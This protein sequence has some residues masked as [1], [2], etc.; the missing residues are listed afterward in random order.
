MSTFSINL[1]KELIEN[2]ILSEE[3]ALCE[4]AGIVKSCGEISLRQK[5]EKIVLVTEFSELYKR[6]DKL[7][8][9]LYNIGCE[10]EKSDEQAYSR[11]RYE[12][13]INYPYAKTLLVDT[14]I[15]SV[16]ENGFTVINKGISP[17]LINSENCA[18]AFLRGV[19]LGGF[20]SNILLSKNIKQQG[21]GYQVEFNLSS[22]EFARDFCSLLAGFDI[23][24]KMITR[25][26][27]YNVYIKEFNQICM[28]LCE[29]GA[30]KSYLKIQDE[31]TLRA[32][33]NQLN[34]QNNCEVANISKTVNASLKQINAINI[35][36]KNLG[37]ENLPKDIQEVCNLRLK[38]TEETLENLAQKLGITKSSLNR[39]FNKII[40][41]AE[42][43]QK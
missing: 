24:P 14:E 12:I 11:D 16:D 19:I 6:V 3:E 36:D 7:L 21:S 10:I 42:D 34:R 35:I 20:T 28:L 39:R 23:F 40:K 9:K 5:K 8:N 4:L 43:L 30:Q 15:L 26:N 25:K 41:L 13:T 17:Y 1:K 18:R 27:S 29:A 32:F 2:N 38:F 37:L 22:P 33:K 31:N